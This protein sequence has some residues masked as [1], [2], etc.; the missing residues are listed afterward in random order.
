MI[1]C[2][3]HDYI[4]IVCMYHYPLSLTL[5]SGEVI[6]CKALDTKRNDN[7]EECIQVDIQGV[8]TLVLLDELS[9]LSVLIENPHFQVVS[10]R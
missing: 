6:T 1:S 9:A 8:Q 10:F 5:K 2:N 3:Q 4:E 7:N